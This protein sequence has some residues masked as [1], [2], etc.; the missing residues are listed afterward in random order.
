MDK[1]ITGFAD[2]KEYLDE[3]KLLLL[4]R[5]NRELMINSEIYD[6]LKLA[7]NYDEMILSLYKCNSLIMG[8]RSSYEE[9]FGALDIE[10]VEED[11]IGR[12]KGSIDESVYLPLD[13]II[14][15]VVKAMDVRPEKEAA[16]IYALRML[17]ALPYFKEES[18]DFAYIIESLSKINGYDGKL[19]FAFLLNILA[20]DQ[21]TGEI[22]SI[23]KRA[24]DFIIIDNKDGYVCDNQ[25][26]SWISVRSERPVTEQLYGVS[27]YYNRSADA[28]DGSDAA[29]DNIEK[30]LYLDE[31]KK[32]A[33]RIIENS[34][35]KR[36]LIKGENGTFKSSLTHILS[37]EIGKPLIH[38]N[39]ASYS[40]SLEEFSK[41]MKLA[42]RE[43]LV[44]DMN[45]S[46]AGIES[47]DAAFI[48]VINSFLT[49][50]I[51]SG[52]LFFL[53]ANVDEDRHYEFESALSDIPAV[54]MPHYS[55]DELVDIWKMY[56]KKADVAFEDELTAELLAG[57]YV[58]TP[59]KIKAAI[60][61]A[62]LRTEEKI[63][64]DTIFAACRAQ[65]K[66]NISESASSVKLGFSWKDIVLDKSAADII[67]LIIS[68]VEKKSM[69][70]QQ[71]GFSSKIHYGSGIAALFYGPPGTGKTMA[72]QVIASE[73]HMELYKV[74]TSRLVDKYVGETEKNIKAV[75]KQAAKGNYVLF[76]D[77]ADAIF[78]KR[79]DAGN[80]NERFANIESA[81]LLQ[82]MEEYEGLSI[83]ATNLKNSIDP[84]FTRRFKYAVPFTL[85]SYESRLDIW[86]SVIPDKAPID[87]EIDFDFLAKNFEL[88]GA[89]IKNIVVSAAYMAAIE[90][91]RI[92]M[93]HI[94]TAMKYEFQK[95]GQMLQ[96]DKL[97]NYAELLR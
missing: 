1:E 11:F 7:Q 64:R 77:E 26:Y 82:C 43:A 50:S 60:T 55:Y 61:D 8:L 10:E 69:V 78:N 51:M 49:N 75:F 88:S 47:A 28:D 38:V 66:S 35:P 67:R 13:H 41:L 4:I 96:M 39:L 74:D 52:R 85:P 15:A 34:S 79:M 36:L 83:L 29:D 86:K 90:D 17:I 81:L 14:T 30:I 73:L 54:E 27:Y 80:A 12:V 58:L 16:V 71:W 22:R 72:A 31:L 18:A 33:M 6:N 63:D 44:Y 65:Q 89:E 84:A 23:L 92:S 32:S 40:Q 57:A 5:L 68:A 19:T 97:G 20:L 21:V 95:Q 94:L 42:L 91:D 76:F 56:M 70:M 2:E 9:G 45:L 46:I 48:S 3:L 25:L 24:M 62:A 87:G 37:D 53:L 93:K 59:G